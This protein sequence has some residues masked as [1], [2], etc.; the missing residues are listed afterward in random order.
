METQN[1]GGFI[2]GSPSPT[3]DEKTWGMLAH[4][5]ALIA[6]MFG[7][8]FLGPLIVMLTKGKESAWVDQHAKE[9]LNFQITVT[10]ALWIAAASFLCL[11]GF[12]LVPL[13]AVAALVLTILAGI[14]A[15]N[16]EMYRYP[17][18]VRLVK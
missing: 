1:R 5:S 3:A 14:K 7:F 15:N 12:V 16:G 17:A 13:V 11:V 2:T 10:V 4:L 6:G 8:P 9:A 18:T